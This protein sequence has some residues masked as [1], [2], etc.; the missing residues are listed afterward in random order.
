MARAVKPRPC[1]SLVQASN[2]GSSSEAEP[3]TFGPLSIQHG[4]RQA[5]WG[6]DDEELGRIRCTIAHLTLAES[7]SFHFNL[8]GH[9]ESHMSCQYG[10]VIQAR[11]PAGFLFVGVS[12]C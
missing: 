3:A 7:L 4:D 8:D 9:L 5:R 6:A 2:S 12:P 10:L 11:C 1:P